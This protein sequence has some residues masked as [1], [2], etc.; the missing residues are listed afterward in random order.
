MIKINLINQ[1]QQLQFIY[2]I[3]NLTN[4]KIYIGLS[5][6]PIKRIKEHIRVAVKNYDD[7]AYLIHKAIKKYGENNFEYSIIDFDFSLKNIMDKEI[8]WIAY[9]NSSN[10]KIGYNMTIGGEH[11][12]ENRGPRDIRNF[13]KEIVNLYDNTDLT[14]RQIVEKLGF[15][16]EKV[17][18]LV[19][20]HAKNRE[21]LKKENRDITIELVL[22]N[23]L[24]VTTGRKMPEHFVEKTKESKKKKFEAFT[25]EEMLEYKKKLSKASKNNEVYKLRKKDDK[26][27]KFQDDI[28]A[29]QL[30]GLSYC[31][32]ASKLS[33]NENKVHTAIK[34]YNNRN[35]TQKYK[36]QSKVF[37]SVNKEPIIND[38]NNDI[39]ISMIVEK[40]N[41]SIYMFNKIIK[42]YKGK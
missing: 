35:D 36:Q 3:K 42:Q 5:C 34:N 40:Y 37:D 15:S 41:I 19:R 11:W 26:I 38:Y 2:K 17:G 4:D 27:I 30:S 31:E 18:R 13:T 1:D 25:E 32:I 20:I 10:R 33:I 7:R 24:K 16:L 29:L 9:Y 39:P 8:Y 14:K 6:N 22:P 21:K 28:K 12:S 23:A